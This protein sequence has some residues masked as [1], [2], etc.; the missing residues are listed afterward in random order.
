MESKRT[1]TTYFIP[2]GKFLLM[3]NALGNP[4]LI[5][6]S[7][8][9]DCRVTIVDS[10]NFP[11]DELE[12]WPTFRL[13]SADIKL[14][15]GDGAYYIYIV[16]PTP[17]NTESTSAFISYN[18]TLVD[19]DGYQVIETEDEEGNPKLEK[20]ELLGKS[21]FKY[22][23]C[24]V[25][26]ARGGNAS[27]TTS[28]SGQGRLLEMDLGVTPAPSTLPGDLNDFD[29]IFKLDK[30]DPDNVN[31]WLLTILLLVKQMAVRLLRVTDRIIFGEEGENE[32]PITDI[33]RTVDS[34]NEFILDENGDA[35]L[36]EDGNPIKDPK[37]VPVSDETIPTTAWVN[38][39]TDGKYLSK[40]KDDR[41]V[42]TVASDKGFE[43]GQFTTGMIGGSGAKMYLDENGKSVLEIDKIAGREELI[44]PSITFNT[45]EVV[46]GDKANT[47][48]YGRIKEVTINKDG[49]SG[50]ATL[51][52]LQE[53]YGTVNVNDIL[54]GVFHNIE[55]GNNSETKEDRNGFLEYSGFFT[56]YFTPTRIHENG[57]GKMSFRYTIQEGTSKHPCAGMNFYA[58]G[59][60]I[61]SERQSITYENRDYKRRLV[62]MNTW[63]IQP[64][65]N[66]VM[67]DGK[68]DGLV[69][70]G[71]RMSGYGTF[72]TNSY[73]TG[74]Q[75]EFTPDQL[76]N[77]KGEDSYSVSIT[78]SRSSLKLMSI[79]LVLPSSHLILCHPLVLLPPIPPSIRV[80]SNESTLRMRWPNYWSFS[81]YHHSFQRNPRADLL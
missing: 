17:D 56:T 48:A 66:I 13:T 3:E 68:L 40:Q 26:S 45:I 61:N 55:G 44:V 11:L 60:F 43:V 64:T 57:Q 67:Q 4:D 18:T 1:A 63:D 24:G 33:K 32:K 51:D 19:R 50:I 75:I 65:K 46:S 81:F 21:G 23:Q 34:D 25:I 80:F 28:P 78:N 7:V 27:A 71:L 10:A 30:V 74:V 2:P 29:K 5:Q 49:V 39:Q 38:K 76:E 72:Q 6:S 35:I 52:L 8:S 16:V 14:K 42:G 59:N 47:F 77:L 70:G 15:L 22:Y 41:S 62:K 53:E 69:I 31:S 54:R 73:F 36:D 37:F 79:E 20:G 12:Q 9:S 58:Y